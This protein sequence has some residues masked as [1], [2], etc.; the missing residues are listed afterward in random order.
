MTQTIC[1]WLKTIKR[2][3]AQ[4][5]IIDGDEQSYVNSTNARRETISLSAKK[6]RDRVENEA[7]LIH[8]I[9]CLETRIAAE[10]SEEAF[11][12]ANSELQA[13]KVELENIFTFQAQGAFICAPARYKIEGEKPS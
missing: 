4:Y 1:I 13:K 5:A 12:Q 9:E 8:D 3:T 11:Q 2:V 7:L 6:K 10:Q